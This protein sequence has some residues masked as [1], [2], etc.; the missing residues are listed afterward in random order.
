MKST[1]FILMATFCLSAGNMQAKISYDGVGLPAVLNCSSTAFLMN[2][3]SVREAPT[4]D[5]YLSDLA[6]QIKIINA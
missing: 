4:S 1:F 3:S 6:I 5:L 2:G